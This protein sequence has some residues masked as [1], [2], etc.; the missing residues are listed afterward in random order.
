VRSARTAGAVALLTVASAAAVVWPGGAGALPPDGAADTPG[1]PAGTLEVTNAAGLRE[2]KVQ[3]CVRGFRVESG[4]SSVPQQFMV[5][6]DDHGS[7]GIGPFQP[8]ASGTWCGEIAT[9]RAA[10]AMKVDDKIPADLCDASKQH[11]LRVLSGSWAAP[12]ATSRSMGRDF[13]IDATCGTGGKAAPPTAGTVVGT[14]AGVGAAAAGGGTGTG[15]SGTGTSTG[16]G[17]GT[18]TTGGSGTGTGTTSPTA[19]SSPAPSLSGLAT[20]RSTTLRVSGT[21]AAL[22]LRRTGAV[23]RGTVVVRSA[24]RLRMAPGGSRAVRTLV[25]RRSYALTSGTNQTL[26]LPL[27]ATARRLLRTHSKVTARVTLTPAGGTAKTTR[28]VLRAP[29]ST[30]K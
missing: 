29:T 6:F 22:L 12:G 30:T 24:S 27:T 21:R 15:G 7:N 9:D 20:V 8:D 11:W 18:G 10:Y 19:P 3:F 17:T 1:T 13:A 2:G 25:A 16:T 26:R 14:D 23:G 4:G 28:V 5:K